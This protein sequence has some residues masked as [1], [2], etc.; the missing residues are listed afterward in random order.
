LNRAALLHDKAG[1]SQPL[2]KKGVAHT[3]RALASY[4]GFVQL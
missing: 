4:A 3:V 2:P 1:A